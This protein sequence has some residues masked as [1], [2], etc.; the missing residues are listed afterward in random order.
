M[1][2]AVSVVVGDKGNGLRLVEWR[3]CQV[4]SKWPLIVASEIWGVFSEGVQ[5]ET[6]EFRDMTPPKG[7]LQGGE[8]Q[9]EEGG[10]S[11]GHKVSSSGTAN[12]SI[13]MKGEGLVHIQ[14]PEFGFWGTVTL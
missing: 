5:G 4:W 7:L 10:L 6:G 14:F 11:K 1:W 12:G 8:G 13:G 2:V 9:A 3:F